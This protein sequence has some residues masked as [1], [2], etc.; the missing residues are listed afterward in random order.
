MHRSWR[1]I[2]YIAT[3]L[4]GF[5]AR[6]DGSIDFLDLDP[7]VTHAASVP[8][9]G[10]QASYGALTSK[11]DV[12]L[13]GRGTYEKVLTFD[14]WPFTHPVI[15]L[16]TGLPDDQDDRIEVVRSLPDAVERLEALA[17]GAVY[18]DGGR[19]IQAFLEAGLVDEIT[20]T[21]VPV[22]IGAGIP[23]FATV[24]SDI[25]LSLESVETEGGYLMARYSV[26]RQHIEGGPL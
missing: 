22:I 4:D 8:G 16:S 14:S 2:V 9:N 1:G 3:S 13:M 25:E 17:A 24:S 6:A 21:R 15:V 7:A 19:V 5:I 18:I 10:L 11:V 23:L 12:V 26:V 20:L